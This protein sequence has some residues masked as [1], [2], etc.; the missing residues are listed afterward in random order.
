MT[1][2]QHP[3]S[4]YFSLLDLSVRP[5][6]T[7]IHHT[8][9]MIIVKMQSYIWKTPEGPLKRQNNGYVGIR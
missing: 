2:I 6:K 3:G 1:V 7:D 9:Q 8:V 5:R 4:F